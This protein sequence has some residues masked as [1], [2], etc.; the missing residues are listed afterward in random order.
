MK[1]RSRS[2]KTAKKLVCESLEQRL[3]L[4]AENDAAGLI[5]LGEGPTAAFEP[6]ENDLDDPVEG[7][8]YSAFWMNLASEATLVGLKAIN[9]G[10]DRLEIDGGSLPVN[11][12]LS[13]S[14]VWCCGWW[15]ASMCFPIRRPGC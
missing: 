1:R 15:R 14:A 2:P 3:L 11:L 13:M 8:R 10:G 5:M 7:S 6:P 9:T 4:S 12:I